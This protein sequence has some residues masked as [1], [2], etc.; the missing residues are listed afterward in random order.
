LAPLRLQS[1][2]HHIHIID[3]YEGPHLARMTDR[4]FVVPAA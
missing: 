1:S 3:Y 2:N 4:L